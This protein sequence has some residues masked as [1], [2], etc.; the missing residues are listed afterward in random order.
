MHGWPKVPDGK[1]TL[2]E[3][4]NV[5]EGGEGEE[6]CH[7]SM[8]IEQDRSAMRPGASNHARPFEQSTQG[9][10]TNHASKIGMVNPWYK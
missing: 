10:S 5:A 1:S 9:P 4:E 7:V 8:Y 2:V 6:E 3:E